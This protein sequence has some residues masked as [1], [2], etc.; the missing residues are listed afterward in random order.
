MDPGQ[1]RDVKVC[2]GVNGGGGGQVF[3]FFKRV[4][5]EVNNGKN[6]CRT[7]SLLK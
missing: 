4:F 2:V 6:C 3:S 5:L 7:C 1:A